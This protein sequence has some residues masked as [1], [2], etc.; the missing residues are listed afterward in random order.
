MSSKQKN[1]GASD[2]NPPVEEWVVIDKSEVLELIQV[3][4]NTH[5][6]ALQ[7]AF[8]QAATESVNKRICEIC[9]SNFTIEK[10]RW[11]EIALLI[12]DPGIKGA[13]GTRVKI[14]ELLRS[15]PYEELNQYRE[16]SQLLENR[17]TQS[18]SLNCTYCHGLLDY[19]DALTLTHDI[20]GK[21]STH[22]H[23]QC[24]VSSQ[25]REDFTDYRDIFIELKRK[26]GYVIKILEAFLR[27]PNR[28]P[29]GHPDHYASDPLEGPLE[30]KADLASWLFHIYSTWSDFSNVSKLY[31]IVYWSQLL[32]LV[33][34]LLDIRKTSE[35]IEVM[36]RLVAKYLDS[37]RSET[38]LNLY[39]ENMGIKLARAKSKKITQKSSAA[40]ALNI[41]QE[42]YIIKARRYGNSERQRIR[43]HFELGH[44]VILDT[45]RM[46]EDD[47]TKMIDYAA[48]LLV[49]QGGTVHQ[50]SGSLIVLAANTHHVTIER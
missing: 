46:S 34:V 16:H 44:T 4:I 1:S 49:G 25:I 36:S 17:N 8:V 22:F 18:Q 9:G 21:N 12:L 26:S 38:V 10:D 43:D 32:S 2:N 39:A 42:T 33:N 5:F 35:P 15:V 37:Q 27:L 30:T 6:T 11:R 48:G 20:E 41:S 14:E 7:E 28:H 19:Q 24:E 50:I 45:L 31:H 23:Y 29:E 13:Q 40:L 3:G 47:I